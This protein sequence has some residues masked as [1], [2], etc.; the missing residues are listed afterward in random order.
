MAFR[1]PRDTELLPLRRREEKRLVLIREAER[2]DLQAIAEIYNHEVRTGVSTFDTE[3][4]E[5]Q[6]LAAW[7][8]SHQCAAYPLLVAEREGEIIGWGSLSPWSDR[9]AYAPTVEG[10]LFIQEGHRQSGVG[11]ALSRALFDRARLAGHRV[12]IGRIEA[13]NEV[14][15]QLMLRMGFRSV[16]VMHEVGEKFGRV[17]D[18]EVLELLLGEVTA[19]ERPEK[20]QGAELSQA[21]SAS[22]KLRPFR[23]A[24][25]DICF[26]LRADAY[27]NE[28]F[29]ELGADAVMAAIAS[30][31]PQDYANMAQSGAIC[32]AESARSK[33]VTAQEAAAEHATEVVGFCVV[34]C[35][36]EETGEVFLIY[37]RR[38]FQRRGVGRMLLR[39]A[40]EW[41]HKELPGLERIVIDTVIPNYNQRFYERMGY[42]VHSREPHAFPGRTVEAVRLVKRIG[43]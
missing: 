31:H 35:V 7:F 13:K 1:G 9:N 27:V 10:S 43:P 5:G 22:V 30:F 29:A 6:A 23:P 32:V 12:V 19:T 3:P 26:R 36:D 25:A 28:F 37:I 20:V 39:W 42:A 11:L 33:S 40:E 21:S 17:L 16:G 18:V 41:L 2:S 34:R 14:S 4:R 15:R 24:D 8:A 38:D